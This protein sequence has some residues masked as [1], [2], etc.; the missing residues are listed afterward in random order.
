M[1]M[2][3]VP[4]KSTCIAHPGFSALRDF[5]SIAVEKADATH[6]PAI[7]FRKLPLLPLLIE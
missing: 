5:N 4:H 3:E 6:S 1:N 2:A 7:A